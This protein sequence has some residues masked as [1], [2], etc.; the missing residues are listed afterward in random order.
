MTT[1]SGVGVRE[2]IGPGFFPL[3]G[4]GVGEGSALDGVPVAER[5]V[6]SSI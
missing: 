3:F 4:A 6:S 2:V 5:L 1:Y